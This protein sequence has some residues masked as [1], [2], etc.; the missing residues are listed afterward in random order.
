M[1]DW[2]RA[3]R[4]I[5]NIHGLD[6]ET[7]MAGEAWAFVKSEREGL[8]ASIADERKAREEAEEELKALDALDPAWDY[9]SFG[10]LALMYSEAS[11]DRDRLWERVNALEK[12]ANLAR[13]IQ[14][15]KFVLPEQDCTNEEYREVVHAHTDLESQLDEQMHEALREVGMEVG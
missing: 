6:D 14:R 3:E 11:A 5:E 10:E 4:V 9:P 15:H 7:S 1:M 12:V 13:T 2:D 8:I